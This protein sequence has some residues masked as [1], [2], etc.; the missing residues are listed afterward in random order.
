MQDV[1]CKAGLI[2]QAFTPAI[3]AQ[4]GKYWIT[5]SVPPESKQSAIWT[6]HS[7]SIHNARVLFQMHRYR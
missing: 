4:C 7:D 5:N 6:K 2:E 1:L 3:Q